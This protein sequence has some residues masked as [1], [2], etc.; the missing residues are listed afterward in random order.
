LDSDL[1]D[2]LQRLVSK[3]DSVSAKNPDSAVSNQKLLQMWDD[4]WGRWNSHVCEVGDEEGE[5][6]IKDRE[7]EPP[8]FDAGALA[9]DLEQI[10]RDMKPMLEPVSRLIDDPELFVKA[11]DEINE[12]IRSFPEW[13]GAEECCELG[14]Q[15]TTCLLEWTWRALEH[16]EM[17]AQ[18]FVERILKPVEDAG[19][20]RLNT[21]ASLN[22][23]AGLP[24][25][26]RAEILREISDKRLE[27]RRIV[28]CRR[29][30][31]WQSGPSRIIR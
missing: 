16:K 23:F 30:L 13:M 26:V 31:R 2:T 21:D 27:L 7:W 10:A 14:P 20:V 15:T 11:A 18:Q 3:A 1:A 17:A 24:V 28:D 4:L 29:D 12:N 22:F 6:A 19:Y 8:Y 5:Y 25:N 9:D